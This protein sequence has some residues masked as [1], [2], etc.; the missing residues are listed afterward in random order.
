M[1]LNSIALAVILV[2]LPILPECDRPLRAERSIQ[3]LD[4]SWQFRRQ[5]NDQ[6]YKPVT[7]PAS[8]EVHEGIQFNGVGIYRRRIP[9]LNLPAGHRVILHFQAVA[10]LAE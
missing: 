3:S 10:T 8:F 6:P 4:G 1:H 5:G 2:A 9:A 7:L